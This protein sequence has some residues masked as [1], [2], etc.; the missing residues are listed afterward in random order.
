MHY[1]YRENNYDTPANYPNFLGDKLFLKTR[2][3]FY[4]RIVKL[5]FDTNRVIQK[6]K[7]SDKAWSEASYYALRTIEGCEG[8]VHIR[9]MNN[10]DKHNGAVVFIGN[11]MSMLESFVLP[12]VI[13]PH[14]KISFVVK[15][16]LVDYPFFGLVMRTTRP[17]IV[18]RVDPAADFKAVMNDGS[19]LLKEGRSVVVFPQSTRSSGFKPD[20]FNSIGIKLARKAKVPVVPIALKTDFWGNGKIFKDVGPL[21]RDKG[22]F[23]EFGEPM[24]IKG[25]GKAEHKSITEFISGKIKEWE[26]KY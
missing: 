21:N 9:N 2:I 6:G 3:F 7:F 12:G 18:G 24:D 1:E 10:I 15:K 19:K 25:N 4:C 16:S 8:K 23:I 5:V 14:K 13:C 11:H 22:V 26:N 17:V 20:E